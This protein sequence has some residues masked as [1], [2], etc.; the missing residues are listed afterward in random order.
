MTSPVEVPWLC[1]FDL[2]TVTESLLADI[3]YD[4]PKVVGPS[5]KTQLPAS[6]KPSCSINCVTLNS[7]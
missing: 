6:F 7:S 2:V 5:L 4:R 3:D 1:D